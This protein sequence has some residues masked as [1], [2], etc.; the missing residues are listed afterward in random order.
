[1]LK[2]LVADDHAIVRRGLR[3]VISEEFSQAMVAE[4]G[5]G[6]DVLGM[7]KSQNC[8]ILILDINFPDRSGLD[9][10]KEV[11]LRFPSLAVVVLSIHPEEQYAIRALKAGA[12]GYLTKESASEELVGAIRKVLAGGKYVSASLGERLVEGI[13]KRPGSLKHE[14]LSDREIQVLSFIAVGKTSTEIANHLSLSIKTIST[15]RVR[16]LTKLGLNSNAEL[17][18]YAL[19]NKLVV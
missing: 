2:F 16:L 15:Y 4:V 9:V 6:N 17:V 19:D 5:R 12:S 11:K 14:L 13:T 3:Q 7:I 18:R 8:N 10:L 1:M